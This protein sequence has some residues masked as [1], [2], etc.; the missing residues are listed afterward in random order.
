M[1]SPRL[2]LLL[3]RA[4]N[5]RARA[6]YSEAWDLQPRSAASPASPR[7]QPGLLPLSGSGWYCSVGTMRTKVLRAA[8]STLNSTLPSINSA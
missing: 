5:R 8:P 4:L 2:I 7:A 3:S 6:E 1:R